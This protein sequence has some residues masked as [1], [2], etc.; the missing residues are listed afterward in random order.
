M[1][2]RDMH[3][4]R[5]NSLRAEAFIHFKEMKLGGKNPT[6]EYVESKVLIALAEPSR[7]KLFSEFVFNFFEARKQQLISTRRTLETIMQGYMS[8]MKHRPYTAERS[9][10]VY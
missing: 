2:S 1:I 6:N 5:Y 10:E 9:Q 7:E 3:Q 4:D 8:E